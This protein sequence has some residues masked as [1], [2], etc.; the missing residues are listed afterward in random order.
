MT[1]RLTVDQIF[2]DVKARGLRLFLLRSGQLRAGPLPGSNIKDVRT[3]V[4][5]CLEKVLAIPRLRKAVI[6]RLT[7]K[8]PREF[9]AQN[10]LRDREDLW[11]LCPDRANWSA[12]E[13]HPHTQFVWWRY[14]GE[15]GWRPVPGR[16]PKDALPPFG[17]KLLEATA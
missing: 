7:P 14:R 3:L 12:H 1:Q 2:R 8:P 17:E 6:D 13:P 5:R 10:G 16:T 9:L 15:A 11:Y 4:S